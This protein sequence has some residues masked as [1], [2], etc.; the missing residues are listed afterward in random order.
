MPVEV[1]QPVS[2]E[3]AQPEPIETAEPMLIETGEQRG[4]QVN[5]APDKDGEVCIAKSADGN[6]QA[7]PSEAPPSEA[8]PEPP[9]K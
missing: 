6:V 9:G 8:D 1:A 7:P 4:E 3:A 5:K 2:T